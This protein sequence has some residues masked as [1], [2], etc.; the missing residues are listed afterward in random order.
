MMKFI[1]KKDLIIIALIILLAISLYFIFKM[2]NK[3]QEK[4]GA[5]A[6]IYY[7]SKLV[8]TVMLNEKIDKTFSLPQNEH[9]IFHLYEDG[10]IRFEESNCPDKVCIKTGR[11]RHIG[12]SSA[13]LPNKIILKI[14]PLNGTESNDVDLIVI[15]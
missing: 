5:K 8:M 6:E 4:A 3:N 12:S 9:V 11:L 13:C 15:K 14:V 1:K 7:E 10:S 2:Y